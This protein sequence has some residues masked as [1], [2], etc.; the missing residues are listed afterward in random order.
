MS[1][2]VIKTLG[3]VTVTTAGTPV[4]LFATAPFGKI[5]SIAVRALDTN[6]G[7]IYLGDAN[8]LASTFVGD[9]IAPDVTKYYAGDSNHGGGTM[10]ISVDS[11]WIDTSVSGSKVSVTYMEIT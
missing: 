6:T 8:V 4:R 3:I 10:L 2:S 11:I 5:S 1:A 9:K 7:N